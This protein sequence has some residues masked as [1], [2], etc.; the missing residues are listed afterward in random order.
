[1]WTIG[2]KS[3][4][5]TVLGLIAYELVIQ[6]MGLQHSLWSDLERVVLALG[7]YSGHYYYKAANH[8]LMT[9][10]QGLKLGLITISLVGL[11][12]ALSVYLYTKL[13][14]GYF[15]MRLTEAVQ[16]TLQQKGTDGA[17]AEKIVRSMQY[18]T[19]ELL[20]I[21]TWVSTVLLGFVFTLVIA[22]FS[23]HPQEPRKSSCTPS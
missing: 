5:I 13:V 21:G 2:I 1:M 19:P 8:G 7:I 22:I 6:L 23:R 12:N 10:R 15:I 18:M 20:L 9:Y 4:L 11:V 3:G 14:D 17:I 16:N